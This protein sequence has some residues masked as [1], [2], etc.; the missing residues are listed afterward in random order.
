[1]RGL[2]KLHLAFKLLG[3]LEIFRIDAATGEYCH[4]AR[5]HHI[6]RTDRH[7][8]FRWFTLWAIAKNDDGSGGNAFWLRGGF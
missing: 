1:M 4:P 3:E 2:I 7:Q 5:K 6:A 8:D